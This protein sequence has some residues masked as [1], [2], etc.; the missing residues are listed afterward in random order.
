MSQRVRIFVVLAFAIPF[1][2]PVTAAQKPRAPAPPPS[3]PPPAPSHPVNSSSP[4]LGPSQPT[5]DFVMF[6]R[7]RVATNDGTPVPNDVLVA[8]VCN[9]KVRQQLYA[10]SHGDFSM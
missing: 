10:S 5:G 2:V 7:G 8:R 3:V 1:L 6:L 9:N 4:N